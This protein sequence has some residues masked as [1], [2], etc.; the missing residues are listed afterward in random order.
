MP[1][2]PLHPAGATHVPVAAAVGAGVVV[3]VTP[4]VHDPANHEAMTQREIARRLAVLKGFAFAGEFER[5]RSYDGPCYFVPA[6]TIVG[7]EEAA[8]MGIGCEDDLFGAVVPHA[9]MGAKSITHPLIDAS[10]TAPTG[11]CAGFCEDVRDAVLEGYAAFDVEDARRAAVRLLEHGPARVKRAAGIGGQGQSVCHDAAELDDVL[12][13]IDAAELA[14]LGLV[15]EENLHAV[16]TYSVGQVQVAGV[17]ASY[18]GTQRL[19]PNN[20]GVEVYGGSTLL[21]ARGGFEA[22]LR[23]PLPPQT[24]HAIAQARRY[25]AAALHRFTGMFGSRRNYDVA[26]GTNAQGAARSGVLEQSW[27]MGGASGAE[28]GALEAFRDDPQLDVVRATTTEVF[29]E[30][31]PPPA[32]ATVY[33]RDVDE[34]V[35]MLTKFAVVERHAHP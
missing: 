22:L 33:F 13:D 28:V 34:R 29:G 11:W 32:H 3:T 26:T 2:C 21:V 23:L 27:R 12:R 24:R 20:R 8:T 1:P 7:C 18:C 6:E 19:T 14:T 30:C 31:D 17:T 25:D 9:F 35:G 4:A 10:A 16:T 15:V 5:S